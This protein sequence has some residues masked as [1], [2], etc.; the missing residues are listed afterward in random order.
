MRTARQREPREHRPSLYHEDFLAWLDEQAEAL[1][2]RQGQKLDWDNLLE[3]IEGMG[4]KER[5]ELK[6]RLRVLLMQVIKWIWQ[7][8]RRGKSWTFTIREQRR[9]IADLLEISPSL[10]PAIPE[11]IPGAWW[12]AREDAA[13]ETELPFSTFPESCPWTVEQVLSDWWPE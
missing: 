2:N 6:S 13:L 3:E 7:P 11:I 10:K 12:D 8:E 5:S 9:G 1:R 4:R